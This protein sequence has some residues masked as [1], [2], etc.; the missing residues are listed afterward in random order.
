VL[1]VVLEARWHQLDRV[2]VSAKALKPLLAAAQPR[3]KSRGAQNPR[4]FDKHYETIRTAMRGVF[5]ELGLAA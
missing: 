4:P 5:D 1:V 3:R 2:C